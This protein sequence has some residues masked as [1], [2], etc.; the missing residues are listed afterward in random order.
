MDS[1]VSAGKSPSSLWPLLKTTLGLSSSRGDMLKYIVFIYCTSIAAKISPLSSLTLKG[2]AACRFLCA[3]VSWSSGCLL[4]HPFTLF[5]YGHCGW[6]G[7]GCRWTEPTL[8]HPACQL[9]ASGL[10]KLH[11]ESC[12]QGVPEQ[13]GS[14]QVMA[15]QNNWI[16][17][18]VFYVRRIGGNKYS[19]LHPSHQI[20]SIHASPARGN[21]SYAGRSVGRGSGALYCCQKCLARAAEKPWLQVVSTSVYLFASV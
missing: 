2:K 5:S 1:F 8:Y 19:L 13:R 7:D 11:S 18:I 20:W 17:I 12:S 14:D 4:S 16:G 9:G 15:C 10:P 6:G 3:S 21:L